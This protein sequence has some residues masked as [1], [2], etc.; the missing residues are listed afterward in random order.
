MKRTLTLIAFL[1]FSLIS[2]PEL[3]SQKWIE[4]M[5]A[6]VDFY[7]IRDSFNQL[8]DGVPYEKG[9]GY[10][11]FK[12]WEW[13]MEQRVYPSGDYFDPMAA[14]NEWEKMNKAGVDGQE[15]T[16]GTWTPLGPTD[17]TNGAGWNA[18]NGRI[19]VVAQ[20][21]NN[22]NTIYIGAASGGLW[23][24]TNG[25]VSWTNLTDN[26]AVLGV[27]GIAISHNSSDTIYIGTGDGDGFNT[28]SVGVLKSTNGGTTWS[29][30]GLNWTVLQARV[31]RKL[32]MHP[33]N[34][35]IIFAAASSGLYKT[36]NGGTSWTQ[37]QNFDIQD[38]EFHP[39]N[40]NIVYSC[41]DSFY[42]STDGGNVFNAVTTGLPGAS[43][44]NRFK[45]A[46]SPNQA[47]WVY[48]LGGKESDHTFEGIYRSVDS[49]VSFSVRTNT[50]N[51]FGYADDGSDDKGQSWY[52][53][54]IAVNP[55]NANEVFIGGVNIWKSTNG[56]TSFTINT[57]WFF[58]N[59][60][61][62]VHADIHELVFYGNRLY[63]GSDGGIYKTE[64]GGTNWSSLTVGLSIT[65]F[66]DI[67]I[68][69]QNPNLILG[70]TQD[71]G[72]NRYNGTTTWTH[73]MGADGM[74]ANINP[75]NQSIMYGAIQSGDIRKSTNGG[76][77][78]NQ[79]IKPDD[80]AGESGAWVTPYALSPLNPNSIFVGYKAIYKSVNG[81]GAWSVLG[82]VGNDDHTH[83]LEIAPSDSST[84]YITKSHLIYKT[85]NGGTSWSN[86]STGLPT[87]FITDIAIDPT[88][89]NRLWVTMSGYTAG[90]KVFQSVNGGSTWTNISSNL[91]NLPANCITYR[92]GSNDELYVGMDVGVYTKNATQTDWTANVSGLPNVIINELEINTVN[93]KMYA[94]SFGRGV[95]V[96]DLDVSGALS[97]PSA[98]RVNLTIPDNSC[99]TSNNFLIN[100]AAAP[101]NVLG[102]DVFLKEVKLIVAHTWTADLDIHLISPNGTVVELSTDNGGSGDNYGN[103]GDSTCSSVT[104]FIM[105]ASTPITA[106]VA[107]FI[108]DF[109]PEGDFSTFN[110]GGPAQG[111][112]TLRICD[113]ATTDIGSLKF[114]ELVF[115]PLLSNPSTCGMNLTIPDNFCGETNRFPIS[116][117]TAP[118][119]QLGT[120]VYLKEVKLIAAHTWTSDLDIHLISPNGTTVELSTDNGGGG[121]HYGNP[122]DPTCSS[123]TRFT[124]SA[125]ASITTGTA[126][127]I[128]DF[129][130]EGNL[131]SFTGSANGLWTLQ[132][133]DDELS[134]QGTLKFVELVFAP[135][136]P[137]PATCGT[138]VPIPD[139]SCGPANRYGINVPL[140]PGTQLG[141]DVKLKEVKLIIEHTWNS[142]LDIHLISPSGV[143]VELSTDNGGSGH[144]YGNPNDP[145]CSN[146][147]TFSMSAATP[148][149]AG[150]SPFIGT[151]LPEG[152]FTA[153]NDGSNPVGFWVLQLC[154][155]EAP[156]AGNLR[157][158]EL[159]FESLCT[160]NLVV[161]SVPIPA[162]TYKSQ[163][164]LL[165]YL[166]TVATST[167]VNFI[168][169]TS[170]LLNN[171]FEV[172]Q[173][174]VFEVLIQAC[175]TPFTGIIDEKK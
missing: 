108:G 141:T 149:T 132:M 38:V 78:F 133:C 131:H 98:C 65:Q 171:G 82:P 89:A 151:Y 173:G 155:D 50:P 47:N 164:E 88:N 174:A 93:N 68:T 33:T 39:T 60:I 92:P 59:P 27:S 40:P 130:P 128:G 41:S 61:G 51:M 167:T 44:I 142:D 147:T 100:V 73:V 54:A 111:L 107:P 127:F 158:V 120:D 7:T 110:N 56:G 32:L 63:C 115:S 139:N 91:P 4:M 162:G 31:I 101:G 106:G 134:D 129:R 64:N 90:S 137:N 80:F 55:A 94:G 23:K 5:D 24:S 21:P 17:W 37:V 122:N 85:T 148:I 12:R 46:V 58:P 175:P 36:T 95:W 26:Q 123:V 170:V 42:R 9:K 99:G 156:D 69:P 35:N 124:M 87:L 154:D 43:A 117:T 102:S 157:Y 76:A 163:G 2:L 135:L 114:V 165:S 84:I 138:S 74:M 70:G 3:F 13:F 48:V 75:L 15:K 29:T 16:L 22:A 19:N 45:I 118:G 97:N 83:N 6:G 49:G 25:G 10:K 112:W 11:Q 145:T 104:R 28:Y 105:S 8:W 152:S 57:Q 77:S 143:M 81:G 53:M 34:S 160:P 119:T 96:A 136:L 30:T 67:A 168:S 121:D 125:P 20:D 103:P 1:C 109:Q 126:P 52:D 166:S 169:D 62:Y 113:D 159:V 146:V 71:N 140:A 72:T 144:N 79:I 161:V 150:T 86:V 172:Q 116:V 18:G 153:F 14:W 66:Y